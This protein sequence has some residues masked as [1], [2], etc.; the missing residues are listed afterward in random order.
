MLA[1]EIAAEELAAE[2]PNRRCQPLVKIITLLQLVI[3]ID[4]FKKY[5]FSNFYA[6]ICKKFVKS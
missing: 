3:C 2:D 1:V 4:S 5:Y 6:I